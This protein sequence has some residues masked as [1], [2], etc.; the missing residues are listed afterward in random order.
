M[1]AGSP[2]HKW[3]GNGGRAGSGLGQEWPGDGPEGLQAH[4]ARSSAIYGRA[5]PRALGLERP[6]DGAGGWA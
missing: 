4:P 1:R 5:S 3:P 6:G 2:G